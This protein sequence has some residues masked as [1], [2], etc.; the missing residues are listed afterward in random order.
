[1]R[2]YS[3]LS[4]T[5]GKY[6]L[7]LNPNSAIHSRSYLRLLLFLS[8]FLIPDITQKA[9]LNS[10]G[11]STTRPSSLIIVKATKVC[12]RLSDSSAFFLCKTYN[13]TLWPIWNVLTPDFSSDIW[14][15]FHH[16]SIVFLK[17]CS[18]HLPRR[19]CSQLDRLRQLLHDL[20]FLYP[21]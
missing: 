1:M 17:S 19:Q 6:A 12:S 4:L 20:P 15:L 11:R 7:D 13:N 10:R 9:L 2:S 5:P 16:A 18:C 14:T 8:W 3:S 21:L